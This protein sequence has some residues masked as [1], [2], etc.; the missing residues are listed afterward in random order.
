MEQ[1]LQEYE[2][3]EECV[4]Y[5]VED[6]DSMSDIKMILLDEKEKGKKVI[7]FDE[8][9]K[10]DDFITNSAALPDVFAKAG[11]KIIVTGTDSLGFIFADNYEL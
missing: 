10:A 8:I 9:T 7:C 4:F 3:P 5:E 1:V 6:E 2:K 11:M